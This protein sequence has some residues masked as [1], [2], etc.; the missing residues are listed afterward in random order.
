[1][2]HLFSRGCKP[3]S[4]W[5][6]GT[7]HEKILFY[8]DTLKPVPY[9]GPQGIGQLLQ[10]LVSDIYQPVYEGDLVIALQGSDGSS[11]TLEPGGQLELSGAPLVNLHQTHA[12]TGLHLQQTREAADSLGIGLL[13][14]AFQPKWPRNDIPWMPKERYDVMRGYMP[15][16]GGLGLD[17]MLR[18]TTVQ[19]N[20]DFASEAD[21]AR[22]MR[23]SSC[24]Q[25]LVT[26]LF[27][28]SPFRNGRP[29]GF[30]STRA[31]CWLDTDA[32]RTGV[33]TC[34]F[35]DDFGFAHWVDYLLDVPMYFVLRNQQYIDCSGCS[36][37][38]FLAGKMP[39]LPGEYPTPDDW[40]LHSTTVFP[41][42]RLKQFLEM[43][44]ADAGSHD[45][46]TA[47]PALWKG[48]LYDPAAEDALWALVA[49]W[50]HAEVNQ[51]RSDVLKLGLQAQFREQSAQQLCLTLLELADAGLKRCHQIDHHT[52]Y[53]ESVYLQ[54][55][56]SIAESGETQAEKWLHAFHGPW[57]QNI[58]MLFEDALH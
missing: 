20:L 40:E 54:P 4:K 17:M 47:L 25:P 18:T 57:A 26:A 30:L 48:L 55:L 19:A 39:V 1:M 44:G 46:I 11:V 53:D 5:A 31:S 13:T 9:H 23:V 29:S 43:R 33:P 6:I 51:L 42:V 14:T 38:D 8:K 37:R 41:E 45:N 34:V 7:E 3:R 15:K 27:S 12:E 36:F 49:D 35:E 16:V 50:T 21:M 28:A 58:D 32:N 10:L 56:W 2:I 24:I 22:K 52:G